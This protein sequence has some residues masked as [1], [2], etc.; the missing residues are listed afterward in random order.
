MF[1]EVFY[2][3]FIYPRTF[4]FTFFYSYSLPEVTIFFWL[5]I[6]YDKDTFSKDDRMGEAE[7]DIKPF[8]EAVKMDYPNLPS[9]TV[10]MRITPSRQNCLAEES[11]ITLIDGKVV[12]DMCLRLRNVECGE[13]EIQLQWI[14]LPGTKGK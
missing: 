8:L 5:Q 11:C 4:G 12:Q 2:A 7:I 10:Y 3:H 6:V 9:G 13:V 14:D 1:I